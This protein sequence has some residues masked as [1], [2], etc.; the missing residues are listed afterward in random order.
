[1]ATPTTTQA[2]PPKEVGFLV[3]Q[4]TKVNGFCLIWVHMH[5]P[6]IISTSVKLLAC[7]SHTTPP[8][9]IQP[10][11]LI[12]PYCLYLRAHPHLLCCILVTVQA[13]V[14]VLE[15]VNGAVAKV[16]VAKTL[17][18]LKRGRGLKA[19]DTPPWMERGGE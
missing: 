15:A 10:R 6:N 18:A 1:M 14:L 13:I 8:I 19:L 3:I 11:P 12:Q 9:S 16:G 7:H 5:H 2:T 4:M 17:Q